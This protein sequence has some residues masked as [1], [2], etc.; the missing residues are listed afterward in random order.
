MRCKNEMQGSMFQCLERAVFVERQ[1][2]HSDWHN[3]H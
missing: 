2:A 1:D 3:E